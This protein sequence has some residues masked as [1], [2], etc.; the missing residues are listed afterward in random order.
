[1]PLLGERDRKIL[2]QEFQH[3][4][5][6]VKLVVFTQEIECQYCRET[7][8]IAEELAEL[9]DKL[10]VEVYD[11]MADREPVQAYRIDK[12]P[13]I[14]IVRGGER[15]K[16]YGIRYYGIPSGYEFS[17]LVED[18]LMVSS[19][20]SGLSQETKEAVAGIRV[21]VHIQVFVTP[22]C[23]YCP[24]A[25][26]LAHQ[27]ALESDWITADMVE[28][29]EFPHLANKYDVMGVPRTVINEKYHIEGAVPE[30]MLLER[31]LQ[32]VAG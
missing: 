9:S 13:A 18:I 8:Q 1:M 29:I 26:R 2:R 10:S 20:E 11:F 6:P 5:E 27:L 32:A 4:T 21:P 15:P 24:R 12:I 3:L 28:A 22:T 7:R 19:G 30:H 16:D 25:V 17:S 31:L 14:A 23:P